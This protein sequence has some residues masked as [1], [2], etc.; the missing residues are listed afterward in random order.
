MPITLF[1][2]MELIKINENEFA[3]DGTPAD[4][5]KV[6]LIHLFKD[7]NFDMVIS[8]INN[9]PN[10]GGD[11][12]YSGT[13]A[14][15][16]EGTMNHIF[17]IAASLD[18]WSEKK[19]Y[20]FSSNFIFE[21]TNLIDVSIL[22]E[23]IVLN[24]NFPNTQ[25]PAGVKITHIGERVYKDFIKYDESG[26]KFFVTIAGDDPGFHDNKGSDL[27]S[28][29]ENY[30]SITPLVNEVFDEKFRERLKYLEKIKWNGLTSELRN[31]IWR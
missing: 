24:I 3:L 29:A 15:A 10:M 22:K 27:N 28:V 5:V 19:N 2:P 18:G 14:G 9:G 21:L 11:I 6:S 31:F 25:K 20:Q 8:G 17:S 12:F 16:R 13:V 23:N 1:K 7:I 30:V 26:G 4:C